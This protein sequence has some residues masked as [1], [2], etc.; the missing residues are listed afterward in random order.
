MRTDNTVPVNKGVLSALAD[1]VK[2]SINCLTEKDSLSAGDTKAIRVLT[3]VYDILINPVKENHVFQQEADKN[4]YREV[5][6]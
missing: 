5:S 4:E 6:Q 1:K 2:Y 3:D